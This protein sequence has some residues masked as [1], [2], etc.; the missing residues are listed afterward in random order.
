M[1]PRAPQGDGI[2]RVRRE[3]SGRGG[4]TVTTIAGLPLASDAMAVLASELK[5]ACGT[6]GTVRDCVIEIQGDH[7]VPIVAE[8]EL[9]GYSVKL[10][11]G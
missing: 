7:R 10:A 11:G 2:V 9:R 3:T 5:R 8:L 6:G 4:K 1:R